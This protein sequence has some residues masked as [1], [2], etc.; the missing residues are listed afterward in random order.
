MDETV[1]TIDTRAGF[2]AALHWGLAQAVARGARRIVCVDPDFADWPLDDPPWLE[3]LG[4]WLRLP[5][6]E[7]VLLA[8][9]FDGLPPRCPRFV[10]WRRTWAH[11]VS[12]WQVPPD[13]GAELPT[14]LLDDGPLL[15]RLF[16]RVHWRGSASLDAASARPYRDEI[17]AV[18]QR[19]EPAMPA[20]QLGL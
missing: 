15:V 5:Q 9:D 6:R 18:V 11:A 12:T 17:D 10:A 14:L 7:L 13:L 2:V 1:P 3:Q 19:S 20:T 4:P 16:D 8:A